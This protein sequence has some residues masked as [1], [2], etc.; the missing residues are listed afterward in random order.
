VSAA[1]PAAASA[2]RVSAALERLLKQPGV[3]V[4][5]IAK[6]LVVRAIDV[7]RWRRGQPVPSYRREDIEDRLSRLVV[8]EEEGERR[9]ELT[10]KPPFDRLRASGFPKS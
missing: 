6:T 5:L 9:L 2:A 10:P 4:S 7:A 8:V 3:T 1:T